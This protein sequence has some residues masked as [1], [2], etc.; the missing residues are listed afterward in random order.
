MEPQLRE[1]VRRL[2][3][4]LP[5]NLL[6]TATLEKSKPVPSQTGEQN[7]QKEEEDDVQEESDS[8]YDEEGESLW[9]I[10]TLWH[11]FIDLFA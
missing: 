9:Q 5:L 7:E 2:Q 1:L 4:N 8:D 10:S 11:S 3:N 6:H